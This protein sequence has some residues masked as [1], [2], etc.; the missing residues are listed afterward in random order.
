MAFMIFSKGPMVC[1]SN[2][3][4]LEVLQQE[5]SQEGGGPWV[6]IMLSSLSF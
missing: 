6:F 5:V 2:L 3:E 1:P 4:P